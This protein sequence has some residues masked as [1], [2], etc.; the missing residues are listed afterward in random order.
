FWLSMSFESPVSSELFSFCACCLSWRQMATWCT[1]H[2]HAGHQRAHSVLQ[3]VPKIPSWTASALWLN[4]CN[5]LSA[6]L[7]EMFLVPGNAAVNRI[8]VVPGLGKAVPFARVANENSFRTHVFQRNE[9]LLSFRN[10]HVVVVFSVHEHRRRM[11]C[12][13]VLQRGA[14]PR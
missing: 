9:Q 4:V 10:R 3:R 6:W 2:H 1:G 7:R 5:S 8:D 14:L 13:D 12:G 11:R